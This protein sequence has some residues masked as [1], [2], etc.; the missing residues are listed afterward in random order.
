MDVDEFY[1]KSRKKLENEL[2]LL[3]AQK[4]VWLVTR[5][6]FL[7]LKFKRAIAANLVDG[8]SCDLW[9]GCDVFIKVLIGY[10][11]IYM[12]TMTWNT[13]YVKW[14]QTETKLKT[15]TFKISKT[16]QIII[17]MWDFDIWSPHDLMSSW[18]NTPNQLLEHTKVF[19]LNG[20]DENRLWLSC[21]WKADTIADK[22]ARDEVDDFGYDEYEEENDGLE[23]IYYWD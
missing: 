17:E 5:Y 23:T 14:N 3:V 11:E 6:G 19:V 8:K 18:N 22:I 2:E 12:S 7:T 20:T 1:W 16:A 4:L 10:H 9:S 21:S 13:K 15:T